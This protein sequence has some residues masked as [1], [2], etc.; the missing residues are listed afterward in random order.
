MMMEDQ[1]KTSTGSQ[2][3][4]PSSAEGEPKAKKYKENKNM[5]DSAVLAKEIWENN[6]YAGDA[7]TWKNPWM[8][9]EAGTRLGLDWK[10]LTPFTMEETKDKNI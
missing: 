1:K 10:G 4:T 9:K 7:K 6:S 8:V 3:K 5:D 2:G